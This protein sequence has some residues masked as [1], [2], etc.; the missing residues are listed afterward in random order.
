MSQK[1]LHKDDGLQEANGRANAEA[2]G[3][4]AVF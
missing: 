4:M 2:R 1:A 3:R